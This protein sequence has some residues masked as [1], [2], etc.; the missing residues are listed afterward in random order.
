MNAEPT[1]QDMGLIARIYAAVKGQAHGGMPGS[2]KIEGIQMVPDMFTEPNGEHSNPTR[3][4]IVT[5][6]AERASGGGAAPMVARYSD[7]SAQ[8][9]LTQQYDRLGG[10]MREMG[11][12]M[13]AIAT[14]VGGQG[15]AIAAL[16]SAV[17]DL[18]KAKTEAET[19]AKAA[20]AAD[21][22]LGKVGTKLEKAR[23]AL[24]KADLGLDVD[25]RATRKAAL[26]D[27]AE[28]LKSAAVFIKK[29]DEED[30]D[31]KEIDKARDT[32]RDL[33]VKVTKALAEI[34]KAE[35][36]EKE[37]EV[38]E[39]AK[40]D[41]AAK[42][43]AE[44]AEAA[45]KAESSEEDEKKDDT[46]KAAAAADLEKALK[47]LS[48]DVTTVKG[49]MEKIMNASRGGVAPPP[50]FAKAE[51]ADVV[52]LQARIDAAMDDGSLNDGEG[53]VARSLFQRQV[54][55]KSGRIS[56][57]QVARDIAA[58][59]SAVRQLFQAAA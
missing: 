49:F 45:K 26:V 37:K 38:A 41:V 46:A 25:D 59:P 5:G 39:K 16:T 36:E 57:D 44:A 18:T 9:G 7:F 34:T 35:D 11:K 19:A 47:G 51:T 21:S 40:A 27:G 22:F 54:L 53:I 32:Y 8:S 29:A 24:R 3:S 50:T 14:H 30:E 33:N 6:P 56:A 58:A 55:A 1:A 13:E 10:I 23:K 42:A 52:S 17:A 31:E 15:K 28:F 43:E 48:M 20:P 4:E 12:A 2:D